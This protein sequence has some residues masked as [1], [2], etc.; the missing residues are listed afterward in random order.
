M[1]YLAATT[2]IR[3]VARTGEADYL[4]FIRVADRPSSAVGR[5]GGEQFL[6][7][8]IADLVVDIE[9]VT[10]YTDTSEDPPALAVEHV[11]GAGTHLLMAWRGEGNAWL[12]IGRPGPGPGLSDKV[13]ITLRCEEAPTLAVRR[14]PTLN[15]PDLLSVLCAT[16]IDGHVAVLASAGASVGGPLP[17]PTRLSLATGIVGSDALA[18]STGV[19]IAH[20]A[21]REELAWCDG[22]G[23]IVMGDLLRTSPTSG[24]VTITAVLPETSRSMPTLCSHASALYLAWRGLDDRVNVM[25]RPQGGINF[26]GKSTTDERTD[27]PVSLAS[28]VTMP[29]PRPQLFASWRSQDGAISI[30]RVRDVPG[31]GPVRVNQLWQHGRTSHASTSAA[32]AIVGDG[33]AASLAVAWVGSGNTNLNV[34]PVSALGDEALI[35]EV[36][37]ALG[38][39]HEQQRSDRDLFVQ[40]IGPRDDSEYRNNYEV[41]DDAQKCEAYDLQ[42]TMHYPTGPRL[43]PLPTGPGPAPSAAFSP[44]DI[45]TL[46]LAYPMTSV[47]TLPF[48]TPS[49]PA[50]S[51]LGAGEGVAI[52]WRDDGSDDL[53]VVGVPLELIY[54]PGGTLFPT[55]GAPVPWTS[56]PGAP[57]ARLT[58]ADLR[59]GAPWPP[60]RLPERSAA[61][62]S[63]ALSTMCWRGAGNENLS[64]AS[65]GDMAVR[66]KVVLP[67][68]SEFAPA[69]A[70]CGGGY[71]L[72]WTGT[73]ERLNVALLDDRGAILARDITLQRSDAAPSV[74]CDTEGR[75]FLAWKGVG[76]DALNVA[77][78]QTSSG[79]LGLGSPTTLDERCDPVTGPSVACVGPW[80]CL[81]WRGKGNDYLNVITSPDLGGTFSQKHVSGERSE[82]APALAGFAT[83]IGRLTSH[84]LVV[85]WTGV[86]NHRVN[87]AIVGLRLP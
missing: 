42:S 73:D 55:F 37:H 29:G 35:H 3:M 87:V 27:G 74:A 49:S 84:A 22:D 23:R 63:L 76:N 83:G 48:T 54:R 77:A 11:D 7:C 24:R 8:A 15:A 43:Q 34:A 64:V 53:S 21:G 61:G 5:L 58:G 80:L 47:L 1:E 44:L 67:D 26:I 28:A 52:A 30:G 59:P 78:V 16:V 31:D 65:L 79:S 82:H 81:G 69:I 12:N 72:A 38:L 9:R 2:G 60:Y 39:F 32:P 41:V 56:T 20:H 45:R 51:Q 50:V 6:R 4:R 62:P 86:G 40:V 17:L 46:Q 13:T 68:R 75:A 66:W 36:G 33:G 14:S 25:V 10:T 18:T 70:R 71:L 19:A 85:A 57:P